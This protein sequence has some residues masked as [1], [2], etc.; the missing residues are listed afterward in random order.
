MPSIAFNWRSHGF[1]SWQLV[2]C[3]FCWYEQ[4]RRTPFHIAT[5]CAGKAH[6]VE[7]R[8]EEQ[9]VVLTKVNGLQEKLKASSNS[10]ANETRTQLMI[11]VDKYKPQCQLNLWCMQFAKSCIPSSYY[12]TFFMIPLFSLRAIKVVDRLCGELTNCYDKLTDF[13]S[14]LKIGTKGSQTLF[15]TKNS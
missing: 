5:C 3:F 7:L 4:F 8:M 15:S 12:L 13:C 10:G 14:E 11:S 2:T 6:K 9:L 1:S